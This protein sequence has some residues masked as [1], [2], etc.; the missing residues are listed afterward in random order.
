MR[1]LLFS[2]QFLTVLQ[3]SSLL[4]SYLNKENYK[5]K[6]LYTINLVSTEFTYKLAASLLTA[7]CVDI[8]QNIFLA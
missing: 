8:L 2:T 6:T 3:N 5:Y 4:V 7:P 1:T